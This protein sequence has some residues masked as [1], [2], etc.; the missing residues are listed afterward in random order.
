MFLSAVKLGLKSAGFRVR[1]RRWRGD[2]RGTKEAPLT[3]GACE[4]PNDGCKARAKALGKPVMANPANRA[5]PPRR[6]RAAGNGLAAA[7]SAAQGRRR[8][9]GQSPAWLVGRRGRC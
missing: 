7:G 9:H 5:C 2:A 8:A 6:E 1:A 3:S 4:S